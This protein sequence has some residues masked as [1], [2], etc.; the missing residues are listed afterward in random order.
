SSREY[1]PAGIT[2]AKMMVGVPADARNSQSVSAMGIP[3]GM[4]SSIHSSSARPD[5]VPAQAISLMMTE[6]MPDDVGVMVGVKVLVCVSV[7]V[8]V[9]MKLKLGLP[10]VP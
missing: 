10:G 1:P 3:L 8:I 4:Y 6:R 7:G 2:P 5:A 9:A